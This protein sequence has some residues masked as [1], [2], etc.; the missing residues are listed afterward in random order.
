LAATARLWATSDLPTLHDRFVQARQIIRK[1]FRWQPTPGGSYQGFVK[2][3][4]QWQAELL[5]AIV[6]HLREQMRAGQP[7][8]W[9]TVGYAVF[10][11]DGTRVALARS[12][13]LEAAFA[14]QRR[15][16]RSASRKQS[17]VTRR[18]P[19]H[20]AAAARQKKATS[21]QLWLTLLWHVGSG[22]PWA[23]R[24]G[25][26]GA[27]ERD[28]LVAMVPELPAQAL[29]VADAG[30]GGYDFWQALLTAGHHFVIRVGANV[31]LLRQLGWTREHAQVVYLW[32]DQV[33]R[34]RQPPLVLRLVVVHDGKQPV[35]LVTD[36][37]KSRL[38][39]RQ[40][41]TIYAARWGVEVFFRTFKQTFGCRKLRSRAAPNARLE[42]EWALIGL[43]GVCL[44]AA[45][46][47]HV[48][49]QTPLR[50]SPAAALHA[51]HRTLR[52]YRVRPET[53][54]ETLW[55]QLRR[56]RLDDYQRRSSKTSRAYPRKKQ[57]PP[58]G[59]PHITL[60]TNLQ[61][62][63]A[64]ALQNKEEFEEFRLSA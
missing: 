62:A 44:L 4:A 42:L 41:A 16:T 49:G 56:A 55:A 39:D 36:L 29:I 25:P 38:T 23:W 47:L 28:H 27:S 59:S 11:G 52:E 6:P 13:S 8:Q 30:F 20:Q 15:R 60:A 50:L 7:E 10:A 48:S 19:K 21:P 37:V 63:Q 9:E 51:F 61:I 64:A 33:A 5:G 40:V 12:E 2:M 1:V 18:V 57:R 22:L 14:P 53:P 3:L 45:R 32:P 34:K 46:E 35:Y 31:R 54:A 26:S 43:W 24:T 17:S 58:I